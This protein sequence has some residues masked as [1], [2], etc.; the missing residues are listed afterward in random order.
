MGRW[1]T[2]VITGGEIHQTN[3]GTA[4]LAALDDNPPTYCKLPLFVGCLVFIAKLK[5]LR[6]E[7]GVDSTGGP[8]PSVLAPFLRN[9]SSHNEESSH[10]VLLQRLAERTNSLQEIE[11][12]NGSA[13]SQVKL[14][15]QL[16]VLIDAL[17][18]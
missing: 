8:I 5:V 17:S 2:A 4:L 7:L 9:S 6:V 1:A 15:G 14:L 11:A 3:I 18:E 16:C 13:G 10:V 12:G